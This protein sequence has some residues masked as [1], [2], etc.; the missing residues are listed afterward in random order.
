MIFRFFI[1]LFLALNVCAQ[2]G[3]E[4]REKLSSPRDLQRR[5][6]VYEII[7]STL[8]VSIAV[9]LLGIAVQDE[10]IFTKRMAISGIARFPAE[11]ALEVLQSVLGDNASIVR[12]DAVR[13][14]ADFPVEDVEEDIMWM[15]G[16][17]NFIVVKESIASAA[18]LGIT[19]AKEKIVKFLKSRNE[20]IRI[21][22]IEYAASLALKET[23]KT[24]KNIAKNDK[25]VAARKAALNAL[26]KIENKSARKDLKEFLG[27]GNL[28]V[29]LET[30][31]ILAKN[32]DPAGKKV[33]AVALIND[34]PQ[35]RLEAAKILLY[36]DDEESRI[37]L[38]GLLND[39]DK[40]VRDFVKNNMGVE[41]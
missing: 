13:A 9:E 22:A 23:Y 40:G 28:A 12:A 5:Q 19:G 37:L 1:G 20:I 38:K 10:D 35:I 32:S 36:Y 31:F 27:D 39:R 3:E 6:A 7:H 2:T 30:A 24:I 18:K 34:S 4:Y 25:S 29:A 15:L 26:I 17:K 21:A 11:E 8:P 33:I 41:R 14:M 16:D